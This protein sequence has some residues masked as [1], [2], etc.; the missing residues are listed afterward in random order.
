MPGK[1]TSNDLLGSTARWT[2]SVRALETEREDRLFA[3]PWAVALAGEAGRAWIEKRPADSVNPIIIRT[4][5]FDDFLQRATSEEKVHQVVLVAAG[6]DTRAFQLNWP[7]ETRIFE[8]DQPSI[9]ADKDRILGSA[10]ASPNCERHSIGIDLTTSWKEALIEGSFDPL[11]GS[12]WLLEGFLFYLTSE[13]IRQILE[14]ITD[15][16]VPGSWLG[17]DI[18][19]SAMLT[20]DLTR[21]WVEMQA[22]AGAPWIGTMDDPL[23]F[24][25]ARGWVGSL[26]Q[27]GAPEANYGRWSLP[28]IP[29][30]M[31]GLP[32]NWFVTAVRG[33]VA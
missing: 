22:E 26:T 19:N 16:A 9:L 7:G 31:P 5:Y 24:L 14:I 33:H 11:L 29:T 12:A 2:A 3:D 23:G 15:L 25:A 4:R 30:L 21:K 32:H 10:G 18:I 1:I 27:A 8:L 20:S 6:L 28:V 13:N 17:F